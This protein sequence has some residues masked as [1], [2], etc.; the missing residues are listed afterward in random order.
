V[1]LYYQ[2]QIVNRNI[3]ELDAWYPVSAQ[4][5]H[6]ELTKRFKRI[7]GYHVRTAYFAKSGQWKK[8]ESPV[9]GNMVH[10]LLNAGRLLVGLGSL[11]R[12]AFSDPSSIEG[13]LHKP[14]LHCLSTKRLL[15][16]H[17][18][19]RYITKAKHETS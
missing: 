7:H 11:E 4:K 19:A 1:R 14:T 17:R 5:D 8:V 2:S 15:S 10:L 16:F 3:G 18:A 6:M 13:I 9:D 12:F